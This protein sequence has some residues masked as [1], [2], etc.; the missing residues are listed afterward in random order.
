MIVVR[1]RPDQPS[2]SPRSR[3]RGD[4]GLHAD[5]RQTLGLARTWP[6]ARPP[7]ESG[8][9]LLRK[10]AA[11]F[12]DRRRIQKRQA[13]FRFCFC[14]ASALQMC[15]VSDRADVSIG[16]LPSAGRMARTP[17]GEEST[18]ASRQASAGSCS[19]GGTGNQLT[20]PRDPC[21]PADGAATASIGVMRPIDRP[22]GA[23]HSAPAPH[24]THE[25][26]RSSPANSIQKAAPNPRGFLILGRRSNVPVT[27]LA[28]ESRIE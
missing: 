13:Q 8:G 24:R 10:R 7:Q 19:A 15:T 26:A 1:G 23:D 20:A 11:I 4:R 2:G 3:Q 18:G 16:I 17:V 12:G 28:S 27:E 6:E 25:V 21:A 9:L 14:H 22:C 5:P